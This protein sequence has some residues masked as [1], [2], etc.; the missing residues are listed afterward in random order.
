MDKETLT[1]ILTLSAMYVGEGQLALTEN[2]HCSQGTEKR[3]LEEA[4]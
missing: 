1:R 3:E 4:M 2:L